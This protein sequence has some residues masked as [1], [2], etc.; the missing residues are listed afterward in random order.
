MLSSAISQHSS[1]QDLKM[2]LAE[3]EEFAERLHAEYLLTYGSPWNGTEI[4]IEIISERV[5]EE[6]G[7]RLVHEFENPIVSALCDS[8]TFGCCD[9]KEKTVHIDCDEVS[10][11][12]IRTAMTHEMFHVLCHSDHAEKY[13]CEDWPEF[14]EKNAKDF[15]RIFLLP[16]KAFIEAFNNRLKEHF[17]WMDAVDL[18]DSDADKLRE[19]VEHLAGDFNISGISIALRIKELNLLGSQYKAQRWLLDNKPR[20]FPK[21]NTF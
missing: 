19:M 12:T 8:K 9:F 3:I 15:A 10:E 1:I 13:G 16:K 6:H 7:Y 11:L 17:C 2:T 20:Y 14:L 18:K 4:N 5:L 21:K